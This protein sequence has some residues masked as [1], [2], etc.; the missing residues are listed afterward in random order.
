MSKQNLKEMAEI[1]RRKTVA[2]LPT[3]GLDDSK[4][5]RIA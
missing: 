2:K 3:F 1:L 4:V 5:A